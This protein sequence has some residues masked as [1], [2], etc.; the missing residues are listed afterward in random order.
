MDIGTE[1]GGR[2]D[3]VVGTMSWVWIAKL[4]PREN[5]QL[6]SICDGGHSNYS[7]P[8]AKT[9]STAPHPSS[10]ALRPGPLHALESQSHDIITSGF[11]SPQCTL[12]SSPMSFIITQSFQIVTC[13]F[14]LY[15]VSVFSQMWFVLIFCCFSL[16]S[17]TK[18]VVTGLRGAEGCSGGWTDAGV[19]GLV[20]FINLNNTSKQQTHHKWENHKAFLRYIKY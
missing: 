5:S 14:T 15:L 19:K 3:C 17:G 4:Y 1:W 11:L 2:S 12:S 20:S 13:L 18:D 9:Q 8:S 7:P 6:L 16:L 10:A